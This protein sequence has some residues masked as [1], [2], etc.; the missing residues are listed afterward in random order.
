MLTQTNRLVCSLDMGSTMGSTMGS[1]HS[2][3]G[4]AKSCGRA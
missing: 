3:V 2:S 4:K 1:D